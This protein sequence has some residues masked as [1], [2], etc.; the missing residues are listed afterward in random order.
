MATILNFGI[1]GVS[2]N[3]LFGKNGIRLRDQAGAFQARNASDTAFVNIEAERLLSSSGTAAS[4]AISF[5]GD[6]DTGLYSSAANTLQV[7]AGGNLAMTIV[8]PT[9]TTSSTV[10]FNSTRAITLPV[11]ANADRPTTPTAGMLRYNSGTNLI[12]F[13]D[14]T[15]WRSLSE[16]NSFVT[17]TPTGNTNGVSVVADSSNDTL[18]LDAGIGIRINGNAGTDTL[19]VRFTREGM[20]AKTPLV[21]ADQVAIFD[22]AN[23]NEPAYATMT[24]VANYIL[25]VI[26]GADPLVRRQAGVAINDNVNISTPLPTPS[27]ANVYVTRIIINVTTAAV[28]GNGGV[29]TDGTNTLVAASEWNWNNTGIYV[30][31]LPLAVSSNGAQLS[32]D[33][34]TAPTTA[35]VATVTAE[36]KIV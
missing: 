29:I 1:A 23:S 16:T 4:P 22:S 5:H 13:Y 11:G 2:G 31:D 12:E 35:G 21:A 25:S 24:T 26:P 10:V 20:S 3:V 34:T 6:P 28:G 30:I 36:Y 7:S 19:T 27:G 15:T 8:S 33:F 14:G 9:V 18:T 32:F 17:I